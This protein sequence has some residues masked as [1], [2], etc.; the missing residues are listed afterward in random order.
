MWLKRTER[1][2]IGW[3]HCFCAPVGGALRYLCKWTPTLKAHTCTIVTGVSWRPFERGNC[4]LSKPVI[5][6][7]KITTNYSCP[8][9]APCLLSLPWAS[10]CKFVKFQQQIWATLPLWNSLL[11]SNYST[12]TTGKNSQVV[13]YSLNVLVFTQCN[14]SHLYPLSIPPGFIVITPYG[15][16]TEWVFLDPSHFCLPD[17]GWNGPLWDPGQGPLSWTSWWTSLSSGLPGCCGDEPRLRTDRWTSWKLGPG[18]ENDS[19]LMVR[20][21]WGVVFVQKMSS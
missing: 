20:S 17:I 12:H 4:A 16:T 3:L 5:P 14:G 2:H 13:H 8:Q 7:S 18:V 1:P 11:T 15:K 21:T 6:A 9:A 10:G 19:E